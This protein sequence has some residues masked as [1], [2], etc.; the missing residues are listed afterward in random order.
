MTG[1]EKK[2]SLFKL[3]LLQYFKVITPLAVI[4][5]LVFGF[6]FLLKPKYNEVKVSGALNLEAKQASLA[7]KESQ[8]SQLQ[9]LV[10]NY[11]GLARGNIDKIEKILPREEDIPGLL[12]QLEKVVKNNGFNILS[13]D[14]NSVQNLSKDKQKD[15]IK[16]LAL[17]LTIEG[18]GYTN[19]KLFLNQIETN[20]RLFDVGSLNFTSGSNLYTLNISTYYSS[21]K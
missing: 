13:L 16:K 2:L 12:A 9:E 10:D 4:L 5:I 14:I 1:E 21:I 7:N 18:G 17:T 15:L 8:L 6:I 3:F 19:L 11:N 20:L